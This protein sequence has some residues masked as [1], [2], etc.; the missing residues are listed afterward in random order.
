MNNCLLIYFQNMCFS[1]YPTL[2]FL[3][4]NTRRNS[5]FVT[6]FSTFFVLIIKH[7]NKDENLVDFLPM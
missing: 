7:Y 1:N 5:L 6:P 3:I 4:I 2:R